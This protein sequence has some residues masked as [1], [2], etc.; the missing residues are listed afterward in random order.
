L[1]VFSTPTFVLSFKKKVHIFQEKTQSRFLGKSVKKLKLIFL[2]AM[3]HVMGDLYAENK[4][5]SKFFLSDFSKN[6]HLFLI[7]KMCT[8]SNFYSLTK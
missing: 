1:P 6:W 3:V 7:R 8:H 4:N 5:S 2:G